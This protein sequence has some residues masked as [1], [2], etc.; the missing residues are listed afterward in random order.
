MAAKQYVGGM[1]LM[2]SGGVGVLACMEG[3]LAVVLAALFAPQ[4]VTTSASA[5]KGG[6]IA[7]GNSI[8]QTL[9]SWNPLLAPETFL[10]KL[11]L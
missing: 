11:G 4:Y 2:V 1:I 8:A 7:T 9:L 3:Q 6:T 10:T 5:S